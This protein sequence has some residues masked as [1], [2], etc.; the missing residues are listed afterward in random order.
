[1]GIMLLGSVPTPPKKPK[2]SISTQSATHSTTTAST[3]TRAIRGVAMR[4]APPIAANAITTKR[5]TPHPCFESN[6]SKLAT[7]DERSRGCEVRA[8][9]PTMPAKVPSPP[10]RVRPLQ[11]PRPGHAWSTA[12]ATKKAPVVRRT[13]RPNRAVAQTRSG[14]AMRKPAAQ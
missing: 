1:M 11:K 10:E 5:F 9:S 4:K 8:I 2:S 13:A 14:S 6:D 7:H 12:M 3:P